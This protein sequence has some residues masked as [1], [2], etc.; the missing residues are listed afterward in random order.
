MY[1][2]I[3]EN[4][5]LMIHSKGHGNTIDV[6]VPSSKD[7]VYVSLEGTKVNTQSEQSKKFCICSF[8]F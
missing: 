5:F 2:H 4:I 1:K 7:S 6:E 8:Y 3:K